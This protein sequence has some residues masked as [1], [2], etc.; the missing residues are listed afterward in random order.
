[1]DSIACL[2]T[3]R[4]GRSFGKHDRWRGSL[5]DTHRRKV[6][7]SLTDLL[8]PLRSVVKRSANWR[9]L[10]SSLVSISREKAADRFVILGP[11]VRI[12]PGTPPAYCEPSLRRRPEH[13]NRRILAG[14]RRDLL[15]GPVRVRSGIA[16]RRRF[17][18]EP[19]DLA[20]LVHAA[21]ILENCG[22]Q[23]GTEA[24]EFDIATAGAARAGRESLLW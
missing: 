12:P 13:E 23:R 14:L 19:V 18:S 15:T 9:T 2:K 22:F 10:I 7:P 21:K 24:A 11:W 6:V 17:L 20:D 5:N 1:M 3:E 4:R 16:L 8:P